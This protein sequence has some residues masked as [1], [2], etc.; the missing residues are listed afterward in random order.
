MFQLIFKL[1]RQ[2]INNSFF[3]YTKL[4]NFINKTDS[5]INGIS[6]LITDRLG[7][8]KSTKITKTNLEALFSRDNASSLAGTT[9]ILDAQL[10][11]P[12]SCQLLS[13]S[14][15]CETKIIRQHV[16]YLN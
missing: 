6:L 10:T 7:V 8:G 13:N 5:I 14:N 15:N 16:I 4:T 2:K 1:L 9:K 11:L 12:T 3:H